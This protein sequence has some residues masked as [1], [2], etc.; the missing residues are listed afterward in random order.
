MKQI[1]AWVFSDLCTIGNIIVCIFRNFTIGVSFFV[2][3]NLI[4]KL[5][6]YT[7]GLPKLTSFLVRLAEV[8]FLSC[9]IF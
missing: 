9:F 3:L 1:I 2:F 6:G 7:L 8:N 4:I 5:Q